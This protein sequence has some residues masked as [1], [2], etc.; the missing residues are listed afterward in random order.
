MPSLADLPELIGFFSYSREDDEGSRGGLSALRDAIQGELSAQ[1]GRTQTDF[2][3][4]QDKAAISLG[5]LWE[6]QI[7][8]GINQSAFFVP[9]ITPRVLKSRHCAMEFQAFLAREAELGR[10]DLVFPIL[11]IPVPALEDEKL[12]R[13]DP[14]LNVV[15]TRQYL[16][17][18]KLR[19]KDLQSIEVRERL[20]LYCGG[21]TRALQKTWVLQDQGKRRKEPEARRR[22]E[23][24]RP[25]RTTATRRIKQ[26]EL[27]GK[28]EE[29]APQRAAE[30]ANRGATASNDSVVSK[31]GLPVLA[32]TPESSQGRMAIIVAAA[33]AVV[34]IGGGI[35]W[36]AMRPSGGTKQ[37]ATVASPSP[38]TVALPTATLAQSTPGI[39]AAEPPAH[40]A[41][42]T[43][44][45]VADAAPAAM[46]PAAPS[47]VS[48]SVPVPAPGPS[49]D[50][51]AWKL[52]QDTNNVGALK[53]FIEQFPDSPRRNDAEAQLAALSAAQAAWH[54]VEDSKDPDQLKRF[55]QQ[56][57]N[58]PDRLVA[59]Q[60]IASLAAPP[61]DP[62]ELTRSLQF[63]LQRVG[64]FQ[65][66]VNGEFDDD[67]KTAW[68]RF[69]KLT[70]VSLSD[71]VSPDAINTVRGINKRVCPVQCP[72]GQHAEGEACIANAPPPQAV[73][74]TRAPA[75]P[76]AAREAPPADS[77]S[78]SIP[79]S[80]GI[81]GG[82]GGGFGG[83]GI[84]IGR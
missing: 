25:R 62:H 47:P 28:A 4:W 19:H 24:E 45:Q 36:F 5:T 52:I 8:Q 77:A 64:C 22:A 42:G 16:D 70:S 53:R 1:L 18:G 67:T 68:H 2:R 27:A 60:R 23:G 10:D 82:R 20:E 32:S 74:K 84:G 57:P 33:F 40:P 76:P 71:N 15:G 72:H 43:N 55:V 17:W 73:A 81:G 66:T 83:I 79:L 13:N 9:I 80:I 12:W 35:A 69:I 61:P 3:I 37:V 21:I 29:E 26:D 41:V 38:V 34:L 39:P 11:Y 50:E 44:A 48:V 65:G 58:S 49:P 75:P 51:V 6:K 59:E 31:S 30:E 7:T 78:P 63:E 14:I 56:F 46:S 54:L